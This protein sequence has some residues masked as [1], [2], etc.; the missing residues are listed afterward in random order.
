MP[1]RMI[2]GV[3]SAKKP[4]RKLRPISRKPL[5][6][7]FRKP[8]RRATNTTITISDSPINMPG[9]TPPMNSLPIETSAVTP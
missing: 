6:F 3:I 8:C 1:P 7:S 2:G 5:N 9:M 4:L